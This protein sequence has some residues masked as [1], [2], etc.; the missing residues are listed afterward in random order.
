MGCGLV[1][2]TSQ[3]EVGGL[4]MQLSEIN[5]LGALP[6]VQWEVTGGNMN[7]L[8]LAV[9]SRQNPHGE[10][11]PPPSSVVV[12]GDSPHTTLLRRP[13]V[14]TQ[15]RSLAMSGDCKTSQK[16]SRPWSQHRSMGPMPPSVVVAVDSLQATLLLEPYRV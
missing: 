14:M 4:F 13:E 15:L 16:S 2:L 8:N 3:S 10:L 11:G 9:S 6:L 1:R 12:V 7:W 5:Q